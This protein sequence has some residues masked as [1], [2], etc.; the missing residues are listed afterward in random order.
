MVTEIFKEE[1]MKRSQ[2]LAISYAKRDRQEKVIRENGLMNDYEKYAK[3]RK[4]TNK[5]YMNFL[6]H[7]SREDLIL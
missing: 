7:I 6:K 5:C 3:D 2:M 4:L 1:K